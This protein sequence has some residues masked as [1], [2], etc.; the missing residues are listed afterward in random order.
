LIADPNLQRWFA[1]KELREA[2]N[3]GTIYYYSQSRFEK[4]VGLIITLIFFVL[5]VIP[6]ISIY[7]LTSVG[8]GDST[9]ITV[10]I[11]VVFTLLFSAAMSLLTK[12]KRH[13]ILVA[14]AAYCKSHPCTTIE[15]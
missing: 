8:D 14:C 2:R 9:L 15:A 5:L 12:A 6:E 4:L 13:E 10:V 7:R 1:T 11:L 3:D